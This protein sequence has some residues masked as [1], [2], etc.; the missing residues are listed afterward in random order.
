MRMSPWLKAW[1]GVRASE[2]KKERR[3]S[4]KAAFKGPSVLMEEL[5]LPGADQVFRLS[6]F[7]SPFRGS[8]KIAE[9][10]G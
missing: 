1:Q 8:G 3:W 2:K 5:P 9:A 6:V 7:F 10:K 4:G